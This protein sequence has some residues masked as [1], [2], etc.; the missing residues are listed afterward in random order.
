LA[1]PHHFPHE[2]DG[3]LQAR[4]VRTVGPVEDMIGL[5]PVKTWFPTYCALSRSSI[6]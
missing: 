2:P 3:A 6:H 4:G 1:R 5:A